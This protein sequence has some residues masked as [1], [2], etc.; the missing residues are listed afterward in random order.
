MLNFSKKEIT[1]ISA[2]IL[3]L[4]GVIGFIA[5]NSYKKEELII[6]RTNSENSEQAAG[7]TTKQTEDKMLIHV[8][9][10]VNKPGVVEIP[11]ESRMADAIDMAGG[12]AKNA[13]IEAVNLAY[14][15]EDGQQLYIPEKDTGNKTTKKKTV[16]NK[17]NKTL[18]GVQSIAV[19]GQNGG[20][21]NSD[22]GVKTEA[23]VGNGQQINSAG[24]IVVNLNTASQEQLDSLP[25]VGPATA[26]KIIEY[27]NKNGRFKAP[28][29]IKKI[30][31][32]GKAKYEKIKE[33]ITI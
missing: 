13:D 7:K 9:G 24:E 2:V 20:I 27:R 26:K 32:I 6:Q 23:L 29:D 4:A 30:G 25:G 19:K 33:R 18:P 8:I 14:K 10:S 31:G 28:E 17:S 12:F 22:K 21:S 15:L 5:M 3:V 1:I 11:K 16:Q